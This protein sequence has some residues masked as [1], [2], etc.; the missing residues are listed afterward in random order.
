MKNKKLKKR[1]I[2]IG[3]C[4]VVLVGIVFGVIALNQNSRR[5]Y[6]QSVSELNM[7]YE[8]GSQTFSGTVA[9]SAQQKISVES[10][11]KV[12]EVFVSKG[13]KV[14]KGDKLFQYDTRL[15]ELSLEEKQLTVSINETTLSNE[16]Q[17]LETYQNIVPVA[18]QPT[19]EQQDTETAADV[20]GAT[21]TTEEEAAEEPAEEPAEEE[22]GEKTYTAQEKA[23]LIADQQITVSRAQT[24]LE[25]SKE[26]LDEAQQALDEAVVTAKMDGTVG[27]IQ[28]PDSIDNTVPFCVII[29]DTGVTLKGYVGEFDY[30]D[31]HV[32]DSL[33]VS[34]YMTDTQ[35]SAEVMN[36]SDYPSDSQSYGSGNPNTSYY[37]FTAFI[38]QSAGFDIGEDVQIIKDDSA[39]EGE[40]SDRIMLSKAYV[41]TDSKGSYVLKDV[42]GRLKR[43]DVK[44]KKTSGSESLEITEGLSLDDMI[45]FPYGSKG[46]EGLLTTTEEQGPSIF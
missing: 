41:R 12:D 9:E 24:A 13:D 36:I 39:E 45:A 26:E 38:S 17:K 4:A 46:K 21:D 22:S 33:L 35:T 40:M 10:D 19:E 27:D 42:D 43:Q 5:A 25:S 3:V 1:L 28:D 6:V 15:L 23:D 7:T 34:S 18:V 16:K 37:E 29:G 2:I 44:T 31:L 30:A 11:K 32:G 14:K 20:T 8:T